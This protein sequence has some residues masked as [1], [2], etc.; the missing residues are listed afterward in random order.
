MLGTNA[1]SQVQVSF[2]P[3]LL[4]RLANDPFI[5]RL[6]PLGCTATWAACRPLAA[7]SPAPAAGT[8]VPYAFDERRLMPGHRKRR[9]RWREGDEPGGDREATGVALFALDLEGQGEFASRLRGAR[10][11]L[12]QE[13]RGL[14]RTVV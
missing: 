9:G 5:T 12:S 2:L 6:S 7:G 10:G 8:G 11:R 14:G 13:S 3:G 4:G 1:P